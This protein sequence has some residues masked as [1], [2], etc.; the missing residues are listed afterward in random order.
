VTTK[1]RPRAGSVK[2]LIELYCDLNKEFFNNDLPHRLPIEW[3]DLP[4]TIIARVRWKNRTDIRRGIVRS[5]FNPF[6]MQ[7]SRHLKPVYLQKQLGMSMLHEMVHLKLGIDVAC[8]EWDGAFD[9]EMFSLAKRGAFR[10][11]W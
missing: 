10:L 11:F 1:K 8:E 5:G 4:G 9:K 3:A 6:V 2:M 7:I